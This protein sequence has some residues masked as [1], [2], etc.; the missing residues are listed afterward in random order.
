MNFFAA[1]PPLEAKKMLFRMAA[2]QK[3]RMRRARLQKM[4]LMLVDMKKAHL[5][6]VLEESKDV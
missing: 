5:N 1:L 4:K 3:R 2:A 6:R